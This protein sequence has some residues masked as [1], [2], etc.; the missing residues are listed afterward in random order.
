MADKNWQ[1]D[2]WFCSI[3]GLEDTQQVMVSR[4]TERGVTRYHA[5]TTSISDAD[6]NRLIE[7]VHEAWNREQTFEEKW[8]ERMAE[9]TYQSGYAYACGYYD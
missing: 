7:R 1:Y 4:T 9:I 2:G 5:I 8:N 3:I 6:L